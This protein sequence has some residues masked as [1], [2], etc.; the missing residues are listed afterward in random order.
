MGNH[1]VHNS[2]QEKRDKHSHVI[3][4]NSWIDVP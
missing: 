3:H 2:S 1:Y 4:I